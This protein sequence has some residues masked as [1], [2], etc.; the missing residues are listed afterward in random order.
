[1]IAIFNVA[2]YPVIQLML[3]CLKIRRCKY[4]KIL[5][6]EKLCWSILPLD[7]AAFPKVKAVGQKRT[8]VSYL[9]IFVASELFKK[10]TATSLR[11]IR[12]SCHNSCDRINNGRHP[13]FANIINVYVHSV[14]CKCVFWQNTKTSLLLCHFSLHLF[15]FFPS[16]SDFSFGRHETFFSAV[17]EDVPVFS[18]LCKQY[19]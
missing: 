3:I 16:W 12:D 18:I 5:H 2:E 19:F 17:V 13:Y 14:N 8:E 15:I 9:K 6:S 7:G 10:V 1:M 4:I 11:Q